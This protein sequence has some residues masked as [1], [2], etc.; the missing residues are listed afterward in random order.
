MVAQNREIETCKL[1][2]S[3][4]CAVHVV[5][6][7]NRNFP[8]YQLKDKFESI[9]NRDHA[10]KLYLRQFKNLE[11]IAPTFP[12]QSFKIFLSPWKLTVNRE[13]SMQIA[14]ED[15]STKFDWGKWLNRAA[16]NLAIADRSISENSTPLSSIDLKIIQLTNI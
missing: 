15:A 3:P 2:K 8:S 5:H 10:W 7:F 9:V 4:N 11:L 6:R 12:P 13:Y 16:S 1:L 14:S